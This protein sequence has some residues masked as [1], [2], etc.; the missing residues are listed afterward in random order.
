MHILALP[1]TKITLLHNIIA[2]LKYTK[3]DSFL[4]LGIINYH[5]YKQWEENKFTVRAELQPLNLLVRVSDH[6]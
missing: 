3:N 4:S 5:S 1:L 2:H 6:M